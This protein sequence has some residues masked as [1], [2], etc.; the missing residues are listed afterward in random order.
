ML[1]SETVLINGQRFVMPT[2][3]QYAPTQYGPQTTGVPQVSP[4][5]PPYLGGAPVSGSYNEGV[6]GYGTA[7]N[8]A[9]V[10]A[11]ARAHPYSLKVSPTWWAVAF[12]LV[13]LVLLKGIHWRDTTLAGFEER[14][15]AG[16]AREEASAEA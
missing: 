9:Q 13:G 8:N 15:R 10:T 4:T 5:I 16:S 11:I 7:G 3:S 2:R 6:G 1:G 12:G 14:G